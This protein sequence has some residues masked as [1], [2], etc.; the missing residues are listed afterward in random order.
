[1]GDNGECIYCNEAL[2]GD[3]YTVVLHCPNQEDID[4]YWYHEPDAN[5][6]YCN[7]KEE[8]ETHLDNLNKKLDE[9]DPRYK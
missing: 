2:E 4:T 5:P 6:V 3:G 8:M 1:M 9:A 7:Y